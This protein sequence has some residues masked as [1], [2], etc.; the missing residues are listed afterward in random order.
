[1]SNGN[2]GS[3]VKVIITLLVLLIALTVAALGLRLFHLYAFGGGSSTVVVPDNL[4][5]APETSGE[6][7]SGESTF[8]VTD[9]ADGETLYNEETLDTPSAE[10]SEL[11]GEGELSLDAEE[12]E[13]EQYATA[14]ELYKGQ[15]GDNER[16]EVKNMLPGDSVSGYYA[17]KVSHKA[18]VTVYF[19]AA[20]T[21]QT[22]MLSRALMIK[23]TSLERGSVIYEGRFADMGEEGYG[24]T[25]AAS[26]P[27]ESI[28]YY[29]IEVYL[30]TSTGNEYQNASLSADF[31]W[32]VRD[33][34]VLEPPP[35][36]D[37][38]VLLWILL[39]LLSFIMILILLKR[40]RERARE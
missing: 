15:A 19:R 21:E 12:T 11:T 2:R 39:L 3:W 37:S 20:V 40:S 26:E 30:P 16:F 14:I 33:T 31:I 10:G 7:T 32:E 5:G 23:V 1:M 27:T 6:E 9:E 34:G 18:E 36:G 29:L 28:G 8:E 35:T 17:V 25:F 13:E 38:I 24:V 22:R 4:I